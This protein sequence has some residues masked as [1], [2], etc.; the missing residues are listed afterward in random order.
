VYDRWAIICHPLPELL[1]LLEIEEEKCTK[2]RKGKSSLIDVLSHHAWYL[3]YSNSSAVWFSQYDWGNPSDSGT[4]VGM[5]SPT[6]NEAENDMPDISHQPIAGPSLAV[7]QTAAHLPGP[8]ISST[9]CNALSNTLHTPVSPAFNRKV[10]PQR[11]GFYGSLVR[12]TAL[13]HS[14]HS[15]FALL[16]LRCQQGSIP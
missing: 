10:L 9:Q 15:I 2:K 12:S 7:S 8:S 16:H 11:C 14:L 5:S 6:K 1:D 3:K 4:E 13:L